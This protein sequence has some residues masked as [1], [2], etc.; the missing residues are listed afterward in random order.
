MNFC[1]LFIICTLFLPLFGAN[2]ITYNV[3]ER[4]DRVDIML[5]FDSPYTGSIFQK[6][7]NNSTSLVLNSLSFNQN[8]NKQLNSQILQQIS[9]EPVKNSLIISLRSESDINLSASKTTDGFGLRIRVVSAVASSPVTRPTVSPQTQSN[10]TPNLSNL[11]TLSEDESIVGWKYMAV[12]AVLCILVI[13]LFI[14]RRYVMS[15][16]GMKISKKSGIFSDRLELKHG[17]E[18]IYERP[19]DNQNRVVLL[20]YNSS[21]YLVLVGTT[22]ILLDRFGSDIKSEEDFSNFFEENKRRI[23]AMINERQNSLANYKDKVAK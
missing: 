20:E 21:Q 1:F 2:L 7:E 9:I 19:L 15:T 11:N 8:I 23:S 4:S 3:Y 6:K 18:T 22:N 14:F 10:Q 17:V 12:V 16:K 13:F 5:S